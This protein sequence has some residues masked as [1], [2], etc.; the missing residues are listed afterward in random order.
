MLAVKQQQKIHKLLESFSP[1]LE[2]LSLHKRP[3]TVSLKVICLLNKTVLP[4]NQTLPL[5][6][7]GFSCFC[8]SL[9]KEKSLSCSDCQMFLTA[10][11]S[12]HLKSD[13]S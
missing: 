12:T 3:D 1:F 11:L 8:S 7:V 2:F 9:Y 5:R 6:F 10:R 13:M 4:V